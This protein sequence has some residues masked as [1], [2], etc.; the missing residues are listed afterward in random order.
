MTPRDFA[1]WLQGY[2]EME[3][4]TSLNEEQTQIIKDH[5]K[6]VFDKQTPEYHT[7]TMVNAHDFPI[8]CGVNDASLSNAQ[9]PVVFPSPLPMIHTTGITESQEQ[10]Q[11]MRRWQGD[12][13]P[14]ASC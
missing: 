14:P 8:S 7:P 1:Y 3:N 10:Y 11:L 5:L 4:P 2:M 6:L 13:L 9:Y 12:D